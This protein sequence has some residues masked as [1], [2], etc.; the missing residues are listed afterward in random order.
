M[1]R[2]LKWTILPVLLIFLSSGCSLSRFLGTHVVETQ[3]IARPLNGDDIRLYASLEKDFVPADILRA[4]DSARVD[5]QGGKDQILFVHGMGDYPGRTRYNGLFSRIPEKYDAHVV[6]FKWPAWIDVRTMPR[7][8]GR[9]SAPY[10]LGTLRTWAADTSRNHRR[11]LMTHSMGA[12]VLRKMLE[13]YK[14]GLPAGFLDAV[15]II[16]P[17]TELRGHARWLE[18]IDFAREVYLFYNA[19]DPVLEPV[20]VYTG[21][22]RLGMQLT[23]LDGT[24]EPLAANTVYVDVTH[25]T[26]WHAYHLFRQNERLE[27]LLHDLI[28]GE[29]HALDGLEKLSERVY[30]VP[31]EEHEDY[32]PFQTSA[33]N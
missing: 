3:E 14:G 5:Q 22:A 8:N 13:E 23:R 2:L 15:L 19:A 31:G 1:K 7:M 24:P 12:V 9:A 6:V 27:R 32:E 26:D 21:K 25:A 17:E 30:M 18:K 16:A 11:V 10:L 28:T 29:G 4:F 33:V 20:R